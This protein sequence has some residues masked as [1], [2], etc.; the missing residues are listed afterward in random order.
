M[1]KKTTSAV[2]T[3]DIVNSSAITQA[4]KRKMLKT[5][6]QAMETGVTLMPD[7][8]PKIFQGYS[9]QGATSLGIIQ[10]LRYALLVALLIYLLAT[11]WTNWY[12]P[13]IVFVTHFF[14]DLWKLN[15]PD[16]AAYFIADQM[17]HI[18]V[19]IV[20]LITTQSKIDELQTFFAAWGNNTQAWGILLGYLFL[21]WPIGLLIGYITQRWRTDIGHQLERNQQSL[22][23]AGK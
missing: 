22:A 15:K 9:F 6:K 11:Q 4:E 16:K 5:L 3:G 1:Q 10:S 23:E 7:W 14:I 12:L 17:L 8:K 19:L 2:F 20:L 13:L 18:T 21:L